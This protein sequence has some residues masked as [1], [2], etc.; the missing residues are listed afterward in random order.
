M[1]ARGIVLFFCGVERAIYILLWLHQERQCRGRVG[2]KTVKGAWVPC[3]ALDSI[4]RTEG[5]LAPW[6]H[7]CVAICVTKALGGLG[8]WDGSE[9]RGLPIFG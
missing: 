8:Q 3:W 7:T 9:G 1:G 6:V 2:G 5:A 4:L